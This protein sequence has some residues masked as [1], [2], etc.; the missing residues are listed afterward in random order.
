MGSS[1]ASIT[2]QEVFEREHKYGAHNY[3]PIPVALSRAE[4]LSILLRLYQIGNSLPYS[5]INVNGT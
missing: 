4:G 5:V 1:S 2:S 3:H